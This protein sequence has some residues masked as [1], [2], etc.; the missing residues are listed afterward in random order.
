M[1]EPLKKDGA[2]SHHTCSSCNL[3]LKVRLFSFKVRLLCVV[4]RNNLREADFIET[5]PKLVL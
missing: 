4:Q 3:L 1:E 2:Q 5:I